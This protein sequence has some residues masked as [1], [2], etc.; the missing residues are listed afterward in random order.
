MPLGLPSLGHATGGVV[1][2]F[3]AL[4]SYSILFFWLTETRERSVRW[5]L[6]EVSFGRGKWAPSASWRSRGRGAG[7]GESSRLWRPIEECGPTK[8]DRTQTG[9]AFERSLPASSR[10]LSPPS[11]ISSRL[12]PAP[13]ARAG[14]RPR[15]PHTPPIPLHLL[16]NRPGRRNDWPVTH[17]RK[18]APWPDR[19]QASPSTQCVDPLPQRQA[20]RTRRAARPARPQTPAS[21]HL[22][23]DL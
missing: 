23:R 16:V 10:P 8:Q 9:H 21:G 22:E 11:S 6:G 5:A 2:H 14:H 18:D 13:Q 20:A 7:G 12:S 19:P 1:L 3:L 17:K 15:K 4:S